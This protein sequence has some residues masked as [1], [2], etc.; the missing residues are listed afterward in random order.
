[1][2]LTGHGVTVQC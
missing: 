2:M 1:M